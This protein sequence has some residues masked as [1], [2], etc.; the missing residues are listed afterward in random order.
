MSGLI[1]CS[2]ANCVS[3]SCVSGPKQLP[4]LFLS[5]F[6]ALT[7]RIDQFGLDPTASIYYKDGK[8]LNPHR[9]FAFP[10]SDKSPSLLVGSA[11]SYYGRCADVSPAEFRVHGL[12]IGNYPETRFGGSKRTSQA[13]SARRAINYIEITR[14]M[15]VSRQESRAEIVGK[16]TTASARSN[17]C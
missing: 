1:G 11:W 4:S 10:L 9:A 6:Y 2:R 13:E 14:G 3:A 17:A 8:S 15:G 5:M 12:P 16:R 7:H